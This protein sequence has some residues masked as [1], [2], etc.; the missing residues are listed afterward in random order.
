MFLLY[1]TK[2][3][4]LPQTAPPPAALKRKKSLPDAQALPVNLMSREEAAV[5]SSAQRHEVRR[6]A[7]EAA[8]YRAN[9]L[10]YLTSPAVQVSPDR[11]RPLKTLFWLKY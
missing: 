5:L 6:Q 10:L 3:R 1:L 9:P 11:T 7:E 8:I 4:P 2:L